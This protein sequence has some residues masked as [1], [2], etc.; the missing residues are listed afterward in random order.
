MAHPR[1]DVF[2][3]RFGT[4]TVL[5]DA[6]SVVP[7]AKGGKGHKRRV[8]CRCDCGREITL[9]IEQLI[10]AEWTACDVCMNGKPRPR[11]G[12]MAS[13][14]TG[15][16]FGRLTVTGRGIALGRQGSSY[17][18]VRCECGSEKQVRR[19]GLLRGATRSCG[20]LQ[21]E[22]MKAKSTTHQGYRTPEYLIWNSMRQRCD[23]PNNP[24]Y[25]HYG[26]R[27][28]TYQE[29]WRDFASF[30]EDMGR[31]P[32][33]ELSLDRIDPNGSY[34]KENC[35][36]ATRLVQSQNRTFMTRG[37]AESLRTEAQQLRAELA[38]YK[39]RFG[40]LSPEDQ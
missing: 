2:N 15:Q 9:R 23:N 38:R 26:G 12:R 32:S 6:P 18:K 1:I 29:S 40:E 31:R 7:G 35:R 14:L 5:A 22:L 19:Q 25:H 24:A 4:L 3:K 8:S 28:I 39:A 10:S 16:V 21:K 36:W 27:G 30:I 34:T 37:E 13:D 33:S 17:W 11:R 20:C